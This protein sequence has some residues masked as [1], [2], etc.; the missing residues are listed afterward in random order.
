MEVQSAEVLE[1][2]MVTDSLETVSDRWK[3]VE[4][5]LTQ[6]LTPEPELT[7]ERVAKGRQ[8]F[9]DSRL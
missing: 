6:P 2:D 8:A 7:E 4:S 9:S 1:E 3:T 5:T